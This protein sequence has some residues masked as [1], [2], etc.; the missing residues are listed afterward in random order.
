MTTPHRLILLRHGE[1][2]WNDLGLFTG[3]T[4]VGLSKLGETEAER[5]GELL[6]ACDVLP[7]VAHT[8][9]LDRAIRTA[10]ISLRACER[11]WV[12]VRRSW[13]L[14][15]RHYG[16]LQGHDKAETRRE[17]GDDRFMLWRRS[18]D[19]PPPPLTDEHLTDDPRYADV[20]PD[21]LPRSECL[22]DVLDRMLPYWVDAIVPDLLRGRTVLVVAHGNSLRALVKHLD[23]IADQDIAELNL[24][25]GVPLVYEL[26]RAMRPIGA[27][28]PRF[29]VSGLYLDPAAAAASIAGVRP[30][31][32]V[33][34][35][36][37]LATPV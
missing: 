24:P 31:G 37:D 30:Q 29:G 9:V 36:S 10:E 21:Q 8:S 4:D 1:S 20:P 12:P 17:F 32:H 26:D 33:R 3:W 19:V 34:P 11:Q 13:R 27:T 18:Y 16:A 28:D 25:T 2:V 6:R 35:V 14:N 15:E 22:K 5:A 7:D 23:A